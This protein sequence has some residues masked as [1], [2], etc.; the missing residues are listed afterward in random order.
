ME[1]DEENERA[2]RRRE[3]RR[4]QHCAASP[5]VRDGTTDK[6]RADEPHGVD[7]IEERRVGFRER[8]VLAIGEHHWRKKVRAKRDDE[9]AQDDADPHLILHADTV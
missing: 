1:A 7:A 4:A 9:H 6:E 8:R 3:E 5:H 2:K